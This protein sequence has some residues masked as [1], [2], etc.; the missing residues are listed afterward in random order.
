[1]KTQQ[2][3]TARAVQVR[4]ENVSME[5]TLQIKWNADSLITYFCNR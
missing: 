1:M 2:A 4:G 5:N 3:I